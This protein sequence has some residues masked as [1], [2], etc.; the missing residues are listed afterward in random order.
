MYNSTINYHYE[1]LPQHINATNSLTHSLTHMQLVFENRLC[2]MR[3]RSHTLIVALFIKSKRMAE[4]LNDRTKERASQR[5]NESTKHNCSVCFYLF[6]L[7]PMYINRVHHKFPQRARNEWASE[8]THTRTH[9]QLASGVVQ[10]VTFTRMLVSKHA[11][12]SLGTPS[13]SYTSTSTLIRSLSIQNDLRR[14]E[15]PTDFV[16]ELVHVFIAST[17]I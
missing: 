9:S 5:A 15:A 10:F 2:W 14:Y 13:D 16:C 11:S 12:H 4:R 1:L 7:V 3:A 6:Q 8:P 17:I